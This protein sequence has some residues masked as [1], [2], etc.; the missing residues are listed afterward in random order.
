[1][2]QQEV[3][4]PVEINGSIV[5][6]VLKVSLTPVVKPDD[7]E[8]PIS[9]E[10]GERQDL[11]NI[12]LVKLTTKRSGTTTEYSYHFRTKTGENIL[13]VTFRDKRIKE[14]KTCILRCTIKGMVKKDG[15]NFIE[16]TRGKIISEGD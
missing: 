16:V 15:M 10:S 9:S 2:G 5:E 4:I 11:T 3:T 8:V 14:G 13:W 6:F 12:T 1:M 7:C